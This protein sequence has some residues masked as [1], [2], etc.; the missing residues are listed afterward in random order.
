MREL[1]RIDL[2]ILDILQREGRI[3]VTELADRI[4]LSATPCSDRVKR[5]EREGVI[6]GYHARVNPAALGKNL[7]VFL[8]IKLSAKSGDVFDKVKKE[9]LYVPE[10]M[11]CH[12]VSGDFDYLVKARL[13]EM[14]E[15]RR[16]LGEILKRLPASAE[17]R[18]YVVMEEIKETL[19]LPVDR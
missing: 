1:D 18:S 4:S 14:N 6:T 5:M 9:L 8:E 2:K 15:Y 16:L 19:Y 12:L 17:S 10:V 7:L 3:S 13:T 11:E